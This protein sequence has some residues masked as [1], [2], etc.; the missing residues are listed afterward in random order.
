MAYGASLHFNPLTD[1]LPLPDGRTFRFSPPS[2]DVWP[3]R[4]YER[5]LGHYQA[6]R[7]D[8]ADV[9][10]ELDPRSD[11]IQLI[12]PFDGWDGRDVQPVELLIKVKGKCSKSAGTPSP[13][14]GVN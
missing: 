5:S 2:G 6:P 13:I 7:D 3:E 8:G 9:E 14:T 12:R 11:R 10:L 4:G 1:S